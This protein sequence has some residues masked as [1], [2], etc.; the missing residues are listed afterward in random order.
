MDEAALIQAAQKGDLDSYNRLVLAYQD[1]IYNQAYRMIGEREAAEDATQEAFI[2]AYHHLASYRGGSFRAWLLRIVTNA[3]YDELRRRQRR[4]TTPLE[5]LDEDG[6]EVESPRWMVDPGEAPEDLTERD[7]LRQAIEHCLHELP[8]DFRT[9]VILVDIQGM[10][11]LEAAESIGKPLGTI[12]SRLARA[13]LRMRDCLQG[14]W[15]LLPENFRLEEE[16][17]VK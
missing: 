7:Q 17:V 2:S 15:E 16:Q 4:P 1:L 11:Y 3:C 13:R 5:P 14:F 12:K 10:D 9:A 6:E 8:G